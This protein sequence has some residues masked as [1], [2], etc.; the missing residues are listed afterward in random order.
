MRNLVRLSLLLLLITSLAA[1]QAAKP[2]FHPAFEQLKKLSGSWVVD[3]GKAAAPPEPV[4][5]KFD[6]IANGSVL[7][8]TNGAGT[9]AEMIT[10]YHLDGDTVVSTHYCA[11]GNQSTV[12]APKSSAKEIVFP[13]AAVS[14]LAP[15]GTYMRLER[16]EFLTPDSVRFVWS[17]VDAKGTRKNGY[18]MTYHRQK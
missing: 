12:R 18:D 16:V 15:D 9:P 14:N 1:A 2:A 13:D 3:F 8:E 7:R 17:S 6:V 11:G 10:L 5:V 4:I